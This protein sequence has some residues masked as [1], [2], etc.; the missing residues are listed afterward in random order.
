MKKVI[1]AFVLLLFTAG[2]FAQKK[3]VTKRQAKVRAAFAKY[4][5]KYKKK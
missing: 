5:E 1:I 2:T 3:H 4:Q